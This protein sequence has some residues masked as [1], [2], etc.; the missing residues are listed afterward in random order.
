MIFT[1]RR[2]LK[3]YILCAFL[4]AAFHSLSFANTGLGASFT[5]SASTFP[6]SAVSFTIKPDTSPWCVFFNGHLTDNVI[7]VYAD[8][9]FINERIAEHL[10]YFVL[11]GISGGFCFD[12]D[13]FEAGTG[14]RFG[15]GL[16]S[17]FAARHIELFGQAVWNPFFAVRKESGSYSQVFRPVNFPLTAGLRFYF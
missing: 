6:D 2:F 1:C 12:D 7:T 5:Y 9:W 10:D 8:D 13:I 15:A 17:F 11:W 16:S 14:C 4:F 3:K